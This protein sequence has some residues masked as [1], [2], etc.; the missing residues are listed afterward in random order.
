MLIAMM[1]HNTYCNPRGWCFCRTYA[2]LA[3]VTHLVAPTVTLFHP[4]V[5][6][7]A[8]WLA[9]TDAVK[10]FRLLSTQSPVV[11]SMVQDA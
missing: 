4:D 7:P 10:G 3:T 5:L 8:L 2:R 11:Q 6:L 1:Y 9:L